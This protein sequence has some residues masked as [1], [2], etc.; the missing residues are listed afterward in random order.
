MQGELSRGNG[1]SD[2][3]IDAGTD[4]STNEMFD[5]LSD[6]QRR[7]ALNYLSES[8]GV[9]TLGELAERVTRAEEDPERAAIALHH[10]H[11]PKLTD[12]GLVEYDPV[13]R[14]VEGGSDLAGGPQ[15]AAALDR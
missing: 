7:R 6:G 14:T 11:L 3:R 13:S 9:V 2:E 5:V 10:G 1:R 12:A 15:L 8:E 4:A